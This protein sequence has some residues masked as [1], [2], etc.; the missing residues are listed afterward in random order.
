MYP[1]LSLFGFQLGTYGIIAVLGI[2]AAFLYICETNKSEKVGHISADDLLNIFLMMLAG[3]LVGAYLL[4]VITNIPY[5]IRNWEKIAAKPKLLLDFLLSGGLVFYGGFIGGSFAVI[6]YC[7]RYRVSFTDTASIIT[8][9]IPLFH[10]FGRIGCFMGGCCWGVEVRWGITFHN[11][12]AAPNGIALMPVQL[13]EAA[14]NLILFLLSAIMTRKATDKRLV[15]P[16]YVV[17]YSFMR[18]TLEFYRGDASRGVFLLST[19]Q[20]IAIVMAATA[21]FYLL[22]S[23]S[24]RRRGHT[25]NSA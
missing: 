12:I 6:W 20:W 2:L 5:L 19:S 23:F 25:A 17:L 14:G 15:L 8:P 22:R 21:L 13:F 10:T 11:S 24:A 4:Y 9:A 3:A 16:V 1:Y 7:R 18:F